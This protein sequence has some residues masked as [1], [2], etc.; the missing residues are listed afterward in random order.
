M[1]RP[2]KQGI[3]YFPLDCQFDDKIELLLMEKGA[4]GLGVLITT[5]Q[6]IYAIEGYFIKNTKDLHLIIKRKI[7][8]D[9]NEVS[10]CINVCLDRNIFD[11]KLHKKHGILTSKG[12]QK[13]YF[14][15]AKKKKSVQIN[16]DYIINGIDSGENWVNVD[17]NATKEKE[18]VKEKEY[19]DYQI[20]FDHWK[21]TLNH[22]R[23]IMDDKRKKIIT[24]ALKSFSVDDCKLAIVGCSKT[25]H[26]MGQNDAK[27]IYDGLHI[28]L[29]DANNIERF[30]RNA[31]TPKTYNMEDY[32][33]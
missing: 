32:A 28:I 7:D 4:P 16:K 20:V 27:Q 8:V 3:D 6:M 10:D 2:T 31:A 9:V 30:M 24:N 26:N 18:E 22:P 15:A 25:P 21:K 13:R 19:K 11:P 14:E 23:A 17:G 12:I 5:L 1:A 33:E 29:K